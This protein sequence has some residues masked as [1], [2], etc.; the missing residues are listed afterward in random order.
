MRLDAIGSKNAVLN[1][2]TQNKC[3]SLSFDIEK[4]FDRVWHAGLL[5]KMIKLIVPIYL[6]KVIQ[7]FLLSRIFRVKIGNFLSEPKKIPWGLPQGSALSP[8]LYN[9]YIHDIPIPTDEVKLILYADDTML[10]TRDRLIG[11]IN[12]RLPDAAKTIFDYYNLWKITINHDKTT[13]TNFSYRTKKQLPDESLQ[14]NGVEV[15]W[16]SEMKYLGVILDKR[17]TY[18]HHVRHCCNKIDAMIRLLYPYIN[19]KSTLDPQIKVHLYRSY[20]LPI[21]TYAASVTGGMCVS[22]MR[23]LQVQQN[24]C[25]RMMMDISWSDFVSN[26]KLYQTCNVDNIS[27]VIEKIRCRFN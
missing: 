14:V 19:R 5:Y 13:L 3:F 12:K 15:E 23:T 16:G 20:L 22:H 26:G 17:L 7:G 1:K 24:K 9:I 27:N 21:M 4:A 6:T 10:M 8:T 18:R 25:L 11:P 2:Y